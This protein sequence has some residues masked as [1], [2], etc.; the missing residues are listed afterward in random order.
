[1]ILYVNGDS[2]TAAAE[3]VNQHA[4][5]EDDPQLAYLGRA[6]HPANLAVSWGRML[7]DTLKA[8]FKCDAESAS[9]NARILRTARV[10]AKAHQHR[11]DHL[12]VIQWSTWERE[13]WF[14]DG[15]F[16]QINA[17]GIDQV[18]DDHKDRYQQFVANVDWPQ[19]Q[20]D[21]HQDIWQFHQELD[22][23][24]I[25]HLFFN[26]N[27]WFDFKHKS[28]RQDWGASYIGPYDS[29]STYDQ[30]LK[31]HG[32]DTVAPNSWHFGRSAHTAWARFVLQYC[33]ENQLVP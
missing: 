14:I 28:D 10:W 6:P 7:A 33:M 20:Q 3:A 9:S 19:K 23:L 12:M 22:D 4:F 8:T 24:G 5:A 27:S 2:H 18:P 15:Q 1:M 11:R 32:H 13:E 21:A 31:R 30:W 29:N 17:S 26:G 16:Y 25:A